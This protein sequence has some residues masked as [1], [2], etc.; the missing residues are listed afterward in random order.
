MMSLSVDIIT[1]LKSQAWR[2]PG[3]ADLATSFLMI[4]LS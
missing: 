1:K 2:D 4:D 3:G